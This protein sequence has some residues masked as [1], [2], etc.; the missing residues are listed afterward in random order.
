MR[1]AV[2]HFLSL[3][4]YWQVTRW[5]AGGGGCLLGQWALYKSVMVRVD[6]SDFLVCVRAMCM[7]PSA[8]LCTTQPFWCSVSLSLTAYWQVIRW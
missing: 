8:L 6:S 1:L 2:C 3:T 4:A 5:G 7:H